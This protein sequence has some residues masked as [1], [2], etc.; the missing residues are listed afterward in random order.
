MQIIHQ[1]P[2][3]IVSYHE[4]Q[5]IFESSW[6]NSQELTSTIFKKEMLVYVELVKK[7]KPTQYLVDDHDNK[8]VISIELQDW[9]NE[10]IF[11][12][13]MHEAVKK[14]ALVVPQ[15]IF[16]QISL[17]QT[18]ETGEENI[19]KIPTQY[20]SNREAAMQWLNA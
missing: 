1:S 13:T 20:F 9:V 4:A 3:F 16:A 19:K 6:Q 11:P 14:F 17:E 10:Y 5:G 12:H 8:F 18:I 15:E 2:Y 7:Y